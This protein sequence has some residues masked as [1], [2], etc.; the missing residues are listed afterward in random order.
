MPIDKICE[1][2]AKPYRVPPA[3]ASSRFCSKA[4]FDVAQTGERKSVDCETCGT[5]F[6]AAKDHGVWQRFCRRDCFRSQGG[7]DAESRVPVSC[8]SC[9]G[10][11]VPDRA[12]R[13]Y[14]SVSCRGAG[15][16]TAEDRNCIN[17][18]A[19]F[20]MI[21][22]F[23]KKR[24]EESC[25]SAECRAAYYT[26]ARSSGWKGGS[27]LSECAGHRFTLLVRPGYVGKYIQ[28]HR[29]AASRALGRPVERGEVVIHINRNKA[30]N[31]TEN[32]FV[33]G[34]MSEFSKMRNGSLPWP[35]KSNIVAAAS[36]APLTA[37][38]F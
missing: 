21:P 30:D 8:A 37:D 5:A 6:L 27:Y 24:P 12:N 23:A 17:C 35:K 13:T 34:S 31:R 38:T 4:C 25:C 18:G 1:G 19:A 15:M 32:L 33:C 3:R 10:V 9:G 28:D 16:R 7:N 36:P 22:S 11:F 26:D 20:T 2:C 14:C 29:L